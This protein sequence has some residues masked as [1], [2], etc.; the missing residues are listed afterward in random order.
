[1][2]VDY[3]LGDDQELVQAIS[4]SDDDDMTLAQINLEL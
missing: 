1:M 4:D 2:D 3:D